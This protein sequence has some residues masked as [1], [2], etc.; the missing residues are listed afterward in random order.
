[1]TVYQTF[2][3]GVFRTF[4]K[5]I[6]SPIS[7]SSPRLRKMFHFPKF[8]RSMNEP[9]GL[10]RLQYPCHQ[11]HFLASTVS[12]PPFCGN[13]QSTPGN[14]RKLVSR[15]LFYKTR[16][17]HRKCF[18]FFKTITFQDVPAKQSSGFTLLCSNDASSTGRHPISFHISPMK[19][20]VG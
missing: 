1:M 19:A 6:K 13:G 4:Q 18:N 8:S 10:F 11:H 5:I 14:C 2:L 9:A 3:V 17:A 12:Q 20:K 7:L 16:H 15:L